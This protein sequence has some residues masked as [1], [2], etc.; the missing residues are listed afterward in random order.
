MDR[1]GPP[2]GLRPGPSSTG[3]LMPPNPTRTFNRFPLTELILV[4]N[5]N[6]RF[7]RLRTGGA[8]LAAFA[9][10]LPDLDVFKGN[11][12]ESQPEGRLKQRDAEQNLKPAAARGRRF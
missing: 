9:P 1:G 6:C 12:Q 7:H 11:T 4:Q 2:A 8:V 5:Q 3:A 10:V